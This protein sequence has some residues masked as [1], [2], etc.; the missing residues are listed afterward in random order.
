MYSINVQDDTGSNDELAGQIAHMLTDAAPYVEKATGLS[1]PETVAVTLVGREGLGTALGAFA[2]RQA[3]RE[4][5]GMQLTATQQRSVDRMPMAARTYTNHFWMINESHLIA[6]SY[7]RPTTLLVPEALEPQGLNTSDQLLDLLVRALAE[8]AQVA[9]CEGR[10]IPPQFFSILQPWPYAVIALS[11]GHAC[12]TSNEVTP[13][14]LGRAV[15][16][17]Q[18]PRPGAYLGRRLIGHLSSA[19][20]ERRTRRA[21]TFVG[22]ALATVGPDR[23][24]QV[25]SVDGLVPTLVE[26][27]RPDQW[28]KRVPA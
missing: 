8:Q 11:T 19:R 21:V 24:N 2:R 4:T 25:W 1:L 28:A 23:F 6:T 10:L 26:L 7:G 15:V 13:L 12:W 9:A 3:E 17:N 27:R 5:E 14:I 22:Q 18:R 16:R 20:E